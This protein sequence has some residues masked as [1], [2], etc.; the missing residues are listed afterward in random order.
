VA[1]ILS[2]LG[3]R[4]AFIT[5]TCHQDPGALDASTLIVPHNVR[6]QRLA[7]SAQQNQAMHLP[8]KANRSH[9]ARINAADL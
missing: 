6:P 1:E 7:F 8:S 5:D 2:E 3:Y 4:T 9:I